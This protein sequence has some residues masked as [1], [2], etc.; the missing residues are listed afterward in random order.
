MAAAPAQMK[1]PRSTSARMMPTSRAVCWYCRG[2]ANLPMISRN[3]NRLSTDS[4]YSVI[5]PA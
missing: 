4:E 3:T 1:I 2:T 5:Q